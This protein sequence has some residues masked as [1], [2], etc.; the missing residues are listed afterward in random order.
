MKTRDVQRS[1]RI[2]RFDRNTGD[3]PSIGRVGRMPGTGQ[4]KGES[5]RRRR[6][7]SPASLRA[8]NNRRKIMLM[9]S[10]I[11]LVVTMGVMGTAVWLWLRPKIRPMVAVNQTPVR[12]VE[13]R[14]VSKFESPTE[15]AALALVKS[16]L[17]N[18]DLSRVAEFFRTGASSPA[19]V[20]GFLENLEKTEGKPIGM[21]W[22]RSLD[23]NGML[24][25]GVAVGFQAEGQ[26]KTR[27][28]LLTPDAGGRWQVD[29]DAFARKVDPAWNE[30]LAGDVKRA[31]V[32]VVVTR[33]HYYNF[34]YKDDSQ[35]VCYEMTTPDHDEILF[36]YCREG[37]TQAE[38]MSRI[39]TIEEMVEGDFGGNRATLEIR[40]NQDSDSRQFE[41]ARVLAEDWVMGDAAFDGSFQ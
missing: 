13:E 30:L 25:E 22:L 6:G 10:A 19:E 14:V 21:G 18:R 15:E 28:A 5:R 3:A 12:K 17:A 23:A 9:W 1:V 38:A 29:F 35:W 34:H 24:L 41:I 26:K 32:R 39:V 2:Q 40:R 27:L 37:S 31:L 11:F 20:V 16:A 4:G 33:R 36:G 7:E 8:R